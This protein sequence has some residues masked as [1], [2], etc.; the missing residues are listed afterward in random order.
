MKRIPNNHY[1]SYYKDKY[2]FPLMLPYLGVQD[3]FCYG[4]PIKEVVEKTIP[5][6]LLLQNN[7]TLTYFKDDLITIIEEPSG[8]KITENKPDLDKV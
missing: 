2:L 3:F 7:R 1:L 8:V 6:P 4:I 5:N